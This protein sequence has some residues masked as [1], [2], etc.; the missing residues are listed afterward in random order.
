MM[1]TF[2][3]NFDI[4]EADDLIAKLL[5]NGCSEDKLS[6]QGKHLKKKLLKPTDPNLYK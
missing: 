6:R 5:P 2:L 4:S 3:C 1:Q